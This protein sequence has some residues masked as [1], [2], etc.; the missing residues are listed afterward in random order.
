MPLVINQIPEM[1]ISLKY[2]YYGYIMLAVTSDNSLL[3]VRVLQELDFKFNNNWTDQE[4]TVAIED[5][6]HY[7]DHPF[8]FE[9]H[10]SLNES[11]YKLYVYAKL[12]FPSYFAIPNIIFTFFG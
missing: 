2:I 9:L 4:Q 8:R 1:K 3:Q 12:G 6:C 7:C 5:Y 10:L 11:P